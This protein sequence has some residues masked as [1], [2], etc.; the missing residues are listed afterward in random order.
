MTAGE[1]EWVAGPAQPN[2][3]VATGEPDAIAPW[4]VEVWRS[5]VESRPVVEVRC[6][7]C[8]TA[9]ARVW[10][11]PSGLLVHATLSIAPRRVG[12]TAPAS[13]GQGDGAQQASVAAELPVRPWSGDTAMTKAVHDKRG[14]VAIVDRDDYWAPLAVGCHRHHGVFD[15]DRGAIA[16]AGLRAARTGHPQTFTVNAA[17]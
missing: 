7:R 6:G 2:V 9:L 16:A 8:Q 10:D 5:S 11:T 14:V 17:R 12:V 3:T 13:L 4:L 15:L 1:A